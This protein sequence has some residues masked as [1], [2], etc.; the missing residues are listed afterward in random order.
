MKPL[1]DDER[2]QIDFATSTCACLGLRKAS[3]AVTRRFDEILDPCGLRSTQVVLLLELARS[4]PM[5][6]TRLAEAL[7]MDKSTLTRNLKPLRAR[8]LVDLDASAGRHKL[9]VLTDQGVERLRAA[10]PLWRQ[11]QEE[12]LQT[13]GNAD[14]PAM[15][16]VLDRATR[17][18]AAA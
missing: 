5:T 3:R 11:A 14:W 9:A 6:M 8:G 1:S 4:G 7:V 15:L 17:L 10:V 12:F 16:T 13:L 2:R 18:G